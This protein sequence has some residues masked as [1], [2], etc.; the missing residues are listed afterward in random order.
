VSWILSGVAGFLAQLVDGALGMAFG[1]TASTILQAAGFAPAAASA[2][3]HTAETFLTAANGLS[4][5]KLGNF[6]KKLF[7]KL[8]VPGTLAAIVGA[9]LLSEIE[10]PW[11]APAVH[12][13]LL[14]TGVIVLL[15]AFGFKPLPNVNPALLGAIGGFVDAIG[16]GGWG[17]IVTGTLIAGDNDPRTAIGSVNTA[18][19]F[20]TISQSIVFLIALKASYISYLAP[21]AIGG[22]A[23]APLAAWACKTLSKKTQKTLYVLVG[24][25][26]IAT[27]ATKL[28][29]ALI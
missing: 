18:E 25:L 12:C 9:Y 20:V 22:L 1:V 8:V 4:H 6:N 14:A 2:T 15:R 11:L 10:T 26:L 24:L 19:F 17:P 27:N 21:F 29:A 23:A 5:I 16:G 13:Y 3:V 28:L 7:L